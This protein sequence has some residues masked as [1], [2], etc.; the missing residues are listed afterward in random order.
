M[1]ISGIEDALG[2]S[3]STRVIMGVFD[4]LT[5]ELAN[6]LRQLSNSIN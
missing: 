1:R 4:L 2:L 6:C 3:D 5:D